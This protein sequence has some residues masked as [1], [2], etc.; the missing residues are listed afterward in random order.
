MKKISK[1][2]ADE[3]WLGLKELSE[4]QEDNLIINIEIKPELKEKL[5]KIIRKY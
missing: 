5:L 3:F 4:S 2:E 1:T